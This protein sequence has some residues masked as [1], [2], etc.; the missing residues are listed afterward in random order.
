MQM[1]QIAFKR[2]TNTTPIFILL[3]VIQLNNKSNSLSSIPEIITII[4]SITI[5]IEL[6]V[7]KSKKLRTCAQILGPWVLR[8]WEGNC[9][10]IYNQ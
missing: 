10:F 1:I 6:T 7:E 5:N 9:L 4:F 3:R 8:F 2:Y